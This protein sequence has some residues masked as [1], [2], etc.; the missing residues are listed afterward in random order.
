[1]SYGIVWYVWLHFHCLHDIM[2][3][4]VSESQ[5]THMIFNTDL[6]TNKLVFTYNNDKAKLHVISE[7]SC[8][9]SRYMLLFWCRIRLVKSVHKARLF[10]HSCNNCHHSSEVITNVNPN[11]Q[12]KVPVYIGKHLGCDSSGHSTHVHQLIALC[13]YRR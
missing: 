6:H 12:S 5:L 9:E 1:M 11:T 8:Q 10:C 3:C 13:S 4:G 2:A 7:Q